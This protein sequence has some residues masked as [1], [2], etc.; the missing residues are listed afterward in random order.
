MNVRGCYWDGKPDGRDNCDELLKA[1]NRGQVHRK[2]K[3][4]YLGQ[5]GV[6]DSVRV[7][8]KWVQVEGSPFGQH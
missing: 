8:Y 2:G 5:E 7:C 1:S 3:V 6:G 4:L